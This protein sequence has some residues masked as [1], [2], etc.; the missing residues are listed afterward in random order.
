[1]NTVEA[2]FSRKSVRSFCGSLEKEELDTVLKAA[3]ASPIGRAQ[4]QTVHLSVISNK[5]LLKRINESAKEFFG[6]PSINPLYD[7]PVYILVSAKLASPEDNVGFSN[8]ATIV[9]N[10]ALAATELGIGACHIWGATIALSQ[11]EE[12]LKELSLPEGFT[13]C[14]GIILGKTEE[15]YTQREIPEQRI[16]TDYIE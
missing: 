5:K 13:P 3:Y 6:N 7:A 14:C 11:K 10:M 15:I 1:M 9:E 4:Y 16:V 2:I 12:I 8:C